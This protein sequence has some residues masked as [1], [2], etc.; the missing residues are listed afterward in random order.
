MFWLQ[1]C[2]AGVKLQGAASDLSGASSH[3]SR[4]C[5]DIE[6]SGSERL[7][8]GGA[9]G[10]N[11]YASEERKLP[12]VLHSARMLRFKLSLFFICRCLCGKQANQFQKACI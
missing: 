11:S 4:A 6:G 3:L 12:S 9:E 7:H 1:I 2:P 8:P 10:T 5:S